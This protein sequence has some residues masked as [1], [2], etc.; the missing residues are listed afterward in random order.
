[1]ETLTNQI[2]TFLKSDSV[3]EIDREMQTVFVEADS[4][5]I[6][7]LLNTSPIY[8][9]W[10]LT[11][12]YEDEIIPEETNT[13]IEVSNWIHNYCISEIGENSSWSHSDRLSTEMHATFNI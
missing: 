7:V 8:G 12:I 2:T 11:I 10:D 13:Y 6:H 1:M 3:I 4:E 9:D 5:K